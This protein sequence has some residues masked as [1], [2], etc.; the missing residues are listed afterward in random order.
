MTHLT[1]PASWSGYSR[2]RDR[3]RQWIADEERREA[4]GRRGTHDV[5]SRFTASVGSSGRYPPGTAGV[6]RRGGARTAGTVV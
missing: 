4:E 6:R 1:H 2:A 3:T 5:S